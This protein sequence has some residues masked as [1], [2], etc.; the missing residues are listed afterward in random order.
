MKEIIICIVGK[1]ISRLENLMAQYKMLQI[2]R[3][4]G[5]DKNIVI[6]YPFHISGKG[7]VAMGEYVNIG[8]NSMI[9]SLRAKCLIG[10]HFVSGPGLIIITGDH[11]PVVGKF[12][13]EVTDEDKDFMDA[14]RKYDQDVMIEEDVWCGANVTILKGV[15]VGRGCIIASGSLVTKSLPPYVIAGG[16]PAKT[17][18][19]KWDIKQVLQHESVLYSAAERKTIDELKHLS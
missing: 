18:K 4:Y 9:M 11:M 12:L 6:Q 19:K 7:N 3:F 16:I 1:V 5:K 13:D 8:R 15:T 2:E 14:E 17:I 10:S